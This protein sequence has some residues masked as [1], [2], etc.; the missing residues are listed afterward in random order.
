MWETQPMVSAEPVVGLLTAKEAAAFLRISLNTLW[1]MEQRGLLNPYRTPGGHR[2]YSI[3]MLRT[4]LE[5]TRV[6]A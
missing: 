3:D 2:R 5:F 6:H 4:Y 1:R